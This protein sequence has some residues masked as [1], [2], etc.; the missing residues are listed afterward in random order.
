MI[1]KRET[2]YAST[3][4]YCKRKAL[5]SKSECGESHSSE[6]WGQIIKVQADQRSDMEYNKYLQYDIFLSTG[7]SRLANSSLEKDWRSEW[8]WLISNCKFLEDDSI[9]LLLNCGF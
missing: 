5:H 9:V 4:L 7:G 8:P 6:D 3:T 2:R 1:M